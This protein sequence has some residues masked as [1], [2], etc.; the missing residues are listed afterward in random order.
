M[1]PLLSLS[2]AFI[3]A[4]IMFVLIMAARGLATMWKKG[5]K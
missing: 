5:K 4:G 2:L 3:F 1:T